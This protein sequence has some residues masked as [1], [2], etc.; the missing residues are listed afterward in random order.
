MP[1]LVKRRLDPELK[2]SL[3]YMLSSRPAWKLKTGQ[4]KGLL[5][6]QQNDLT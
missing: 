3:G 1:T 4:I 5:D 2:A 6:Y